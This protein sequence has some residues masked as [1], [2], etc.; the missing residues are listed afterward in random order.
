MNA[1]I[2]PNPYQ[3]TKD[4][5]REVIRQTLIEHNVASLHMENKKEPFFHDVVVNP[6]GTLKVT[7]GVSSDNLYG[8]SL[9]NFYFDYTNDFA[10]CLSYIE[11]AIFC[12]KRKMKVTDDN[13][14]GITVEFNA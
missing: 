8:I 12:A 13:Y 7:R 5:Y 1:N 3:T 9:D 11:D 10:R 14:H 4:L 6:N 2:N